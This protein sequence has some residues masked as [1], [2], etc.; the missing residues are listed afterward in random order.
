MSAISD[1][2]FH[3]KKL[4]KD[5]TIKHKRN[6]KKEMIKTRA[7]VSEIEKKKINREKLKPKE[8]FL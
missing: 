1:L 3:F 8:L 5:D 7:K 6:A 2:S 4:E